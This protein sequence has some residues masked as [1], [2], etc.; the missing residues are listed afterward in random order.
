MSGIIEDAVTDK[1]RAT[2]GVTALCSTRIYP[3]I[4]PQRS[5]TGGTRPYIVVTKT[6]G[7]RD[8]HKSGGP[9]GVCEAAVSVRCYGDTY[10]AARELAEQVEFAMNGIRGTFGTVHV[11]HSLLRDL[12][13]ASTQP[14]NDDEMGY[15]CVAVEFDIAHSKSTS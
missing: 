8:W 12:Y 4:A 10:K 7:Q 5:S 6:P 9:S 15:P 3:R 13:D 1:L 11:S 14:L 2:A